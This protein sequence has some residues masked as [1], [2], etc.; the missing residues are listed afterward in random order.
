MD[1]VIPADADES[2]G[3]VN[4]EWCALHPRAVTLWR[5]SIIGNGLTLVAVLAVAE[6]VVRSAGWVDD[7]P[8]AVVPGSIALVVAV[9]AMV[10]PPA[11]YARWRYRLSDEALELRRG[12]VVHRWSVVPY[13]RVQQIDLS[14]GP[15]D[16]FLGLTSADLTTAAA[17]TDGSVPALEPALAEE[18]RRV[19]LE[20]AG[21]GD[22]V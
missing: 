11:A 22:A 16:R 2:S 19:V 12:V 6:L 5:L 21:R 8:P 3:L 4:G 13:H 18:F 17:T 9:V 20:R 7:V 15:I 10:W 14:R 1:A